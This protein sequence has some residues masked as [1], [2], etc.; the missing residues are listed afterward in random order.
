M[1]TLRWI[2]LA[3]S[4]GLAVCAGTSSADVVVP[5]EWVGVWELQSATYDCD[6]GALLY[7]STHR[8]TICPGWAFLDPDPGGLDLTCTGGADEDSYVH[9]C[10]GSDTPL[11]NCTLDFIF[12]ANGTRIGDTYTA[13]TTID[14]IYTGDC[15]GIQDSCTRKE[16]TATR[17]DASPDECL[18]TGEE[19]VSW[20]A[21]KSRYR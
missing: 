7:S 5:Q 6:T 21:L 10:E 20:T 4:I 13:I 3:A 17:I 11:P 16:V 15:A 19:S 9:H 1:K 2:I 8:E 12:D 18:Q 14:I